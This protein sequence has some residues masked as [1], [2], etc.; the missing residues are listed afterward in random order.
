MKEWLKGHPK[1]SLLALYIQPG[2]KKS[3]FAGIHG[4]RLKIKIKAPPVEGEANECLIE[5]LADAL[6]VPK[7]RVH[8]LSGESSRQ[9]LVLVELPLSEVSTLLE[10]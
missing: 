7:A 2:A 10:S 6:R 8:L 9:K 5:F 3:E 1:G 4:Q